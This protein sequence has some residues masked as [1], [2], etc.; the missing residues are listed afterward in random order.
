[1]QSSTIVEKTTSS[2]PSVTMT[3]SGFAAS[4]SAFRSCF[5]DQLPNWAG[6]ICVP[7]SNSGALMPAAKLAPV[8]ANWA[9]VALYA[10]ATLL[11]YASG[12]TWQ[13]GY[14]GGHGAS[15]LPPVH[16]SLSVS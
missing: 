12:E 4:Y 15:T 10:A 7:S 11:P 1:M 2:A 13:S 16:S 14:G 3:R 5:V 6:R 9:N 8:Q